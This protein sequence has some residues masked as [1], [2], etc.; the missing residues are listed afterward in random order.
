VK[1]RTVDAERGVPG[2]QPQQENLLTEMGWEF[3]SRGQRRVRDEPDAYN[4]G[5]LEN[6]HAWLVWWLKIY[7]VKLD[8][9]LSRG[10]IVRR[11]NAGEWQARY[12]HQRRRRR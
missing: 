6:K 2:G 5:E 12:R 11:P 9:I 10:G 3:R 1:P 7:Q 4:L 8:N